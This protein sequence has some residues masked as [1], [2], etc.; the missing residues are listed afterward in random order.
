MIISQTPY[1]SFAGIN[2]VEPTASLESIRKL[3]QG[4]GVRDAVLSTTIDQ[5][6]T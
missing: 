6:M 4:S 3:Q 5:H 2:T 1:R